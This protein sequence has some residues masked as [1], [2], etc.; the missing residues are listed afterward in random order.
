MKKM[1]ILKFP[2]KLNSFPFFKE[3]LE[4][5]YHVFSMEN[6]KLP[7]YYPN[8][9]PDYPGVNLQ[10]LSVGD[11]FTISVF[12]RIGSGENVRADGGYLDLEVEHI[13]GETVSGVIVTQLPKEFP[14]QA[15]DSLEIY[16]DEILYKA[17]ITEH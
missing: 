14:L 5:G 13:E 12:F 17:Q 15:G 4:Q 9:F 2:S 3:I 1:N 6:A 11:V 8:K 7:D 10:H 16:P